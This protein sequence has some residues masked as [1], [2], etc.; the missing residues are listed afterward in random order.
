MEL[1]YGTALWVRMKNGS[2]AEGFCNFYAGFPGGVLVEWFSGEEENPG[3]VRVSAAVGRACGCGLFVCS[4]NF[5]HLQDYYSA[6][7]NCCGWVDLLAFYGSEPLM[8]LREDDQR[9][10]V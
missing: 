1:F 9:F 2:G 7:D 3:N 8:M 4:E 6:C 10:D 5:Y